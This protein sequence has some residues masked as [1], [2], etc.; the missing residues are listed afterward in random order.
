MSKNS[1][2]LGV[3][4]KALVN[5]IQVACKEATAKGE[6][7][8]REEVAAMLIK[9]KS[10]TEDNLAL[11]TVMVGEA[12]KHGEVPGYSSKRGPNGGIFPVGS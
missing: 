2:K 12:V 5:A 7:V 10:F 4:S 11:L 9:G 8:T 6:A 3:F 1:K